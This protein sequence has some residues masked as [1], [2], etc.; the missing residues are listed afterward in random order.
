M[1]RLQLMTLCFVIQMTSSQPTVDVTEQ[2]NDVSRCGQNDD[3]VLS[4]LSQLLT[5]NSQLQKSV[6]ELRTT[7]SE[8]QATN[9]QLQ[10]D[11]TALKTAVT[12]NSVTGRPTCG[13]AV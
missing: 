13:L 7:I 11:V 10:S 4:V 6:S 2:D 9:S 5:A 12:T 3:Q 8:L 1:S